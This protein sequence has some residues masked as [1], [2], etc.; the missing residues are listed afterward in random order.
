MAADLDTT[1]P[2]VNFTFLGD[3]ENNDT[4]SIGAPSVLMTTPAL[5]IS[6]RGDE[7]NDSITLLSN[8]TLGNS[9]GT[10]DLS[11]T[12]ETINLNAESINTTA[13]AVA[14]TATF[15]GAVVL[16]AGVTVNTDGGGTDGSVTFTSTIDADD[17]EENDRTLFV[18][19][20]TGSA[21]FQGDIGFTFA[22]ADL[23]VTAAA[24]T[25]GDTLEP[26]VV[27]VN[28]DD[29]SEAITTFT[30][31]VVLAS[32]VTIN[33]DNRVLFATGDST[34][35]ADDA[36]SNDRTLTILAG[37]SVTF[38]GEI[39][40]DQPLANLDVTAASI[41]LN[42]AIIAV[43][44][45]GGNAVRFDGAVTL[46]TSVQIATGENSLTFTSTIDADNDVANDWTLEVL[47]GMG[48]VTFGG[49]IGG[50]VG[51]ALADL[52]VTAE[53]II[54]NGANYTI[55]DGEDVAVVTFTGAVTLGFE[56]VTINTDGANDNDNDIQF[57]STIDADEADANDRALFVTAGLGTATFGGDIGANVPLADLDVTADTINIESSEIFVDDNTAG[58]ATVTFTGGVLL[59]AEGVAIDTDKTDPGAADSD[60]TFAGTVDGGHALTLTAG[61]GN[62]LFEGNVSTLSS[63]TIFSAQDVTFNWSVATIE[64]IFQ[65]AGTGTTTFSGPAM[66][67][68]SSSI[69]TNDIT[70]TES[71]GS[72]T[73]GGDPDNPVD[74][75]LIAA[76]NIDL[77]PGTLLSATGAADMQFGDS[78]TI[79]GTLTALTAKAD[80]TAGA[81][82]T[83]TI[84][85]QTALLD[86]VDSLADSLVFTA[87]GTLNQLIANGSDGVD[88][89]VLS[90]TVL[91]KDG[92]SDVSYSYL[93][94]QN[95]TLNGG[96][97]ADDIGVSGGGSVST[98]I[99]GD[100]GVD[101]IGVSGGTTITV[102][103]GLDNDTLSLTGGNEVV[104]NGGAGDDTI[105]LSSGGIITANVVN[106]G[107][108]NDAISVTGAATANLNGDD[109]NDTFTVAA[110]LQGSIVAGNGNDTVN[111]NDGGSVTVT[112]T[113]A[114]NGNAGI[115]TLNYSDHDLT[116]AVISISGL[117]SADGFKGTGTELFGTAPTF[118]NINAFVG[119]GTS[120][121]VAGLSNVAS[122]WLIQ[123]PNSG[124]YTG[125]SRSFTFSRATSLTGGTLVDTFK[126][127]ATGSVF[128]GDDQW[129]VGHRCDRLHSE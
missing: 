9:A 84:N 106:G 63:L 59:G 22:L 110:A 49:D 47:S 69:T 57:T 92:N 116:A 52:D 25:L 6:G 99:N 100:A 122:T 3:D 113:P 98:I 91:R 58:A 94:V 73:V 76:G 115:D 54:L 125:S 44:N 80:G 27:N 51:G 13:G 72:L 105:G 108:G 8:L 62:L 46:G 11:L 65:I 55:N 23:D 128:R 109:G 41:Y 36:G 96:D 89:F 85:Y 83:L 103:G 102:D 35:N 129:R 37:E 60:V 79:S 121:A 126:S 12:A 19:T 18:T 118:D 87:A 43:T 124:T 114:I 30:G 66:A 78:L 104:M 120:T 64:A 26:K 1:T 21:T 10:G 4:I 68:A 38:D 111:V 123:G 34:I 45:G 48:P 117:G 82:N 61:D 28:D 70:F 32:D 14:G 7:D 81:G 74:I 53:S 39:G 31:A 67:G 93:T 17:S 15:T 75:D 90:S 95:V 107:I 77:Q 112:G 24:I 71:V 88:V 86:I 50:A 101:T 97:D 127:D 29:V 119:N 16:G 5:T 33:T 56:V 42:S 20:G 2:N 40:V